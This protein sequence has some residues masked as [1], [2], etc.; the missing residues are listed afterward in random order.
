[1]WLDDAPGLFACFTRR[2]DLTLSQFAV[3]DLEQSSEFFAGPGTLQ[4][5]P[6]RGERLAQ[7][8]ETL[9]QSWD[10]DATNL[11]EDAGWDG[12]ETVRRLVETVPGFRDEADTP[13]GRLEFNKLAHLC[14]A[15][16]NSRSPRPMSR[17]DTFPVYP[18]YMLPRFL[19]HRRVLVYDPDLADT[20][21]RRRLIPAG[22]TWELAIRWGTVYAADRLAAHLAAIGNRVSVPS[23]DYAMWFE[24]VLGPQAADM[25]EHHR[26][27]TLNY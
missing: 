13:F 19:R 15:M 10:G 21:D 26:T 24:A 22:S 9:L 1:M 2:P 7:V 17:L 18:D 14:V 16:I 23:L 25:G 27:V 11:A 5:V 6:E 4:L 12:P 20:I 8:A 3:F